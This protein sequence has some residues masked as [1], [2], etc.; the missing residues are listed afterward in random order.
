MGRK[1][2][3]NIFTLLR[4]L[5]AIMFISL[6]FYTTIPITTTQTLLIQQGSISHIINNLIDKNHSLSVIDRYILRTLGKPQAGW[7][8][9]G[10]TQ[11]NRIDFLYK[12]TTNKAR[13]HDVTL[14]PGQTL[15]VFF[16]KVAQDMDLNATKLQSHYD[17]TSPYLEAGI[18]SDTYL[19]PFGMKEESL[20][21]FLIQESEKKYA[22]ISGKIFG[23]YDTKHWH[24]ILTIASIVQKEAANA[25]EMPLVAS[26]VYNRLEKNMPLQMDGTLNYGK[27]SN[28]KVTPERIRNDTSH[29]NTYK[30]RGLPPSPIG[31]VSIDSILATIKPAKTDY[32][33]FVRNAQGTHDFSKTFQEHRKAIER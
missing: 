2:I 18:F 11:L 16:E 9:I 20:V 32:L 14:I 31:S 12:L 26:V 24:K 1:N 33:Y 7:I 8:Y 4:H 15:F 5:L 17:K 28:T 30:Y 21:K 29:F 13:L 6:L 19:V 23:T 27:Y 10:A 25:R 3:L 22:S